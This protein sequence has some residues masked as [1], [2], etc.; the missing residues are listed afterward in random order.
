M[1]QF[2][3]EMLSGR[4]TISSKRT[5]MWF[6]IFIFAAAFIYNVVTSHTVVTVV[7][8][9]QRVILV[10]GKAP[11]ESFQSQLFEVLSM[12]I[13]LVFGERA[14]AAYQAIKGRKIDLPQGITPTPGNEPAK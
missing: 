6:F 1:K 13:L 4:D 8:G 9:V 7:D 5:A 3:L 10:P 2:V 12:L 14:L 11:S